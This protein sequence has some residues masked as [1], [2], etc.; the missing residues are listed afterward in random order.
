MEGPRDFIKKAAGL[1]LEVA[2]SLLGRIGADED[3]LDMTDFEDTGYRLTRAD[4]TSSDNITSPG[5]IQ[6]ER[7]VRFERSLALTR[8][9]CVGNDDEFQQFVASGL[10]TVLHNWDVINEDKGV[11]IRP[12][13]SI[14]ER[15]S[16]KQFMKS[17]KL[18]AAEIEDQTGVTAHIGDPLEMNPMQPYRSVDMALRKLEIAARRERVEGKDLAMIAISNAFTAGR[19]FNRHSYR[20]L[21]TGGLGVVVLESAGNEPKNTAWSLGRAA[22]AS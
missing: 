14:Q 7:R 18:M 13:I 6:H 11:G 10:V 19:I 21:D 5:D 4:G 9:F 3:P 15:G 20:Q 22:S 1:P 12:V 16:V 2:S 8:N 17:A